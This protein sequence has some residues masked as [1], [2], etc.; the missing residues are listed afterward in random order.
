[1]APKAKDGAKEEKMTD[2]EKKKIKQGN[3]K[4]IKLLITITSFL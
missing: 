1:M 4:I 2:A 3:N